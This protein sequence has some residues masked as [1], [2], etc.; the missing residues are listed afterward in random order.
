M[1]NIKFLILACLTA[2]FAY[3]SAS[4]VNAPQ[5]VPR[6]TQDF[7]SYE[8]YRAQ[9]DIWGE[10][11]KKE[12]NNGKAWFNY[13]KANRYLGFYL[14]S[15]PD[16]AKNQSVRMENILQDMGKAIPNS[17]EYNYCKW[18]NAGNN[19]EY[20]NYLFKAFEIRDDSAEAAPDFIVYYE[21]HFDKNKRDKFLKKWYESKF[22]SQS[23]LNYSYNVLMS[24]DKNAVIITSG[25]NDTYPLWI[26]Q[27]VKGLRPDVTVLN[28]QLIQIADYREKFLKDNKIAYDSRIFS[29]KDYIAKNNYRIMPIFLKSIA[30]M[31]AARPVYFALTNDIEVL[32]EI[33][34][35]LYVVGLANKYV[36]DRI[37]NIAVLRKNWANFRLDYLNFDFYNENNG[38]NL[39]WAPQINMN[40][41]APAMLLYEHYITMEDSAQAK[42]LKVLMDKLAKE[43]KQEDYLKQYFEYRKK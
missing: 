38:Y 41:I 17:F 42:K 30:E 37:D 11:I 35:N 32:S 15:T 26:L 4:A 19:F 33:K 20:V 1:I 6:F 39:T 14:D 7:K 25:D 22:F 3:T 2:L 34:S 10:I 36:K 31:N 43:A 28:Q 21:T 5:D 12:P 8:W 16:G 13:F 24:L 18:W 40:Y 27:A 23:L 9:A 29:D